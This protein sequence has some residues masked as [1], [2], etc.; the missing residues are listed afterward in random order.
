VYIYNL[1]CTGIYMITCLVTCMITCFGSH[2]FSHNITSHL[3]WITHFFTTHQ[4]K[5]LN[6]E[7]TFHNTC[8][9]LW[10]SADHMTPAKM[11]QRSFQAAKIPQRRSH[12][13][14]NP[15]QFTI[16]GG[17][18]SLLRSVAHAN[19]SHLPATHISLRVFKSN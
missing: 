4:Q 14:I 12:T 5:C 3:P 7:R 13:S 11:A 10:G 16:Y 17:H 9:F 18:F 2:V 6:I 1:V 19:P 15:S 8:D